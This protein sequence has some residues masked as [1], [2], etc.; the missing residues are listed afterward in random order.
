[1]DT[2]R[3]GAAGRLAD[4]LFLIAHDD[5]SGKALVAPNL[6]NATLAGAVLGELA[7]D[8][9]ISIMKGQVYVDDHRAWH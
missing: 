7:L 3:G 4:D 6:L 1:M 2:Y 8:S 5:Y 9:R